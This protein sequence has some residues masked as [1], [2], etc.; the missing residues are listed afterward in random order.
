MDTVEYVSKVASIHNHKYDYGN[1]E[2][3]NSSTKIC[4][5]CPD[6]GEFWQRASAHMSGQGCPKCSLLSPNRYKK[7]KDHFIK[8]SREVHGDKYDYNKSEYIGANKYISIICPNH[9]EFRQRASAHMSGQGCPKCASTVNLLSL[10]EF[11]KRSR[12][13]HGDKYNYSKSIYVNAFTKVC[14]IC[15]DHGEFWQRPSIHVHGN[16]CPE[17]GMMRSRNSLLLTNSE[18]V[19]RA[20]SVHGSKYNYCD[21][22]YAHSKSSVDIICHKHGRFTQK[23]NYHLLGNGCPKCA[24]TKLQGDVYDYVRSIC[25]GIVINNDRHAIDPL[26]LDIYVPELK[27]GVEVNGLYWH[28]YDHCETYEEKYYHSIKCDVCSRS[29]ILLI[30]VFENEWNQKQD[31][32]KSM[33]CS[34]LGLIDRKIYARCCDV[35]ELKNDVY[36]LFVE[37]N[38]IQGFK[39][40]SVKFGLECDGEVVAVMSFNINKKYSWEINR[41]CNKLGVSVVGG[42]GKLLSRF[43]DRYSPNRLVT[44]ADRRYSD[45]N[46]YRR[47]GFVHDG[48]TKPNYFYVKR[49]KIYSRHQFMKHKLENKLGRFDV[50]LSESEN[51]FLNGYRR[52]WDAGSHRFCFGR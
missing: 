11:I 19:N 51:M 45:G 13:K 50:N 49:D 22:N 12:S 33:I 37:Q 34:K 32:V 44:Y 10:D 6:H 21:V 35:V 43:I 18:F 46:L 3:V 27:V 28:S 7:S 17:C 29:G 25:D 26:E 5:I 8:R 2:Y 1:V 41:F 20:V 39:S 4:I 31:I 36:R 47:L 38:H 40:A 52:M 48:I 14:I 16:G 23:P 42:A 9:G 24:G 30:Q 15:P